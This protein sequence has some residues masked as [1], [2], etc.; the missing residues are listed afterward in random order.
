MSPVPLVVLVGPMGVG[1]STVGQLLAE[2]LGA[3]YRDTDDDIVAEQGREIAE[4]FLDEG[5]AASARLVAVGAPRGR[6]TRAGVGDLQ[7][8]LAD[9]AVTQAG[10]QQ[11]QHGRTAGVHHR[12]GDQFGDEED[13]RLGERLVVPYPGPGEP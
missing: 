7:A 11:S 8:D 10:Q 1:K 9:R 4:I 2:R 3:A 6:R 5:E 13:Q 12:V